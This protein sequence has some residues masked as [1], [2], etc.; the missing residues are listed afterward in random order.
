M[1]PSAERVY[2]VEYGEFTIGDETYLLP[3]LAKYE[4]KE[5]YDKYIGFFQTNRPKLIKRFYENCRRFEAEASVE[6]GSIVDA[7]SV[8]PENKKYATEDSCCS[9]GF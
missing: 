2:V 8:P 7:S 6:F 3:M 5:A 1:F 4:T 9:A